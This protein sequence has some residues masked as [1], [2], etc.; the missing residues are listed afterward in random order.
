MDQQP[1]EAQRPAGVS[2][3]RW[4]VRDVL[5]DLACRDHAGLLDRDTVVSWSWWPRRRR[6]RPA[7]P[8]CRLWMLRPLVPT[9]GETR[10]GTENVTV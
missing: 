6:I 5:E 3:G 9:A 7:Q 2:C 1:T 8:K 10:E 4:Q